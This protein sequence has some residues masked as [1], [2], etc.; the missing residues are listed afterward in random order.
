M[1]KYENQKDKS[2]DSTH[3]QLGYNKQLSTSKLNGIS[4]QALDDSVT[5][6]LS[7]IELIDIPLLTQGKNDFDAFL[8]KMNLPKAKKIFHYGYVYGTS[9]KAVENILK[10]SELIAHS[11]SKFIRTIH[12]DFIKKANGDNYKILVVADRKRFDVQNDILVPAMTDCRGVSHRPNFTLIAGDYD[13]EQLAIILL[14]QEVYVINKWRDSPSTSLNKADLAITKAIIDN[15]IHHLGNK[16]DNEEEIKIRII[17]GKIATDDH[18]LAVIDKKEIHIFCFTNTNLLFSSKKIHFKIGFCKTVNNKE[19]YFE[20]E[21]NPKNDLHN[22]FIHSLHQHLPSEILDLIKYNDGRTKDGCY[23]NLLNTT[24]AYKIQLTLSEIIK[25][26]QGNIFKLI[27]DNTYAFDVAY[28]SLTYLSFIHSDLVDFIDAFH[29]TMMELEFQFPYQAESFAPNSW[30]SY[31]SNIYPENSLGLNQLEEPIVIENKNYQYRYQYQYADH[32]YFESEQTASK[33]IPVIAECYTHP[34]ELAH[35]VF[36][37]NQ[38]HACEGKL[39]IFIGD[40]RLMLSSDRSARGWQT[41][42]SNCV[43]PDDSHYSDY[44]INIGWDSHPQMEG[45]YSFSE[46]FYHEN[47]H[48]YFSLINGDGSAGNP[49]RNLAQSKIVRYG[50][51]NDLQNYRENTPHF[52]YVTYPPSNDYKNFDPSVHLSHVKEIALSSKSRPGLFSSEPL[53]NLL[54]VYYVDVY[55]NEQHK[56]RSVKNDHHLPQSRFNFENHVAT[57]TSISDQSRLQLMSESHKFVAERMLGVHNDFKASSHFALE[58]IPKE[59]FQYKKLLANQIKIAQ[60]ELGANWGV[61][62][63]LPQKLSNVCFQA[64]MLP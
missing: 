24:A 54:D 40:N 20:V 33:A 50:F 49:C 34:S 21:L 56:F 63:F 23:S 27:E 53:A 47:M 39:K 9:K 58:G 19:E 62:T 14:N 8:S 30:R 12:A 29:A 26:E 45:E 1:I 15:D 28:E 42:L 60:T 55:Y 59:S 52:R 3:T 38:Q 16:P 35:R 37:I 13:I 25:R 61:M 44:A 36:D 48:Q 6:K 46:L 18:Q 11:K 22:S 64:L 5:T 2:S 17:Q 57:V 41:K 51:M 31:L 7:D 10:A 43:L 4:S 32:I